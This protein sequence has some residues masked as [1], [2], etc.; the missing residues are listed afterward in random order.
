M[1]TRTEW[2][3]DPVSGPWWSARE[4]R[5]ITIDEACEIGGRSCA[6]ARTYRRALALARAAQLV[7]DCEVDITG[8]RRGRGGKWRTMTWTL[9]RRGTC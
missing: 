9:A 8:E 6:T 4:R 1:K 5:W 2:Y 7:E 3:I